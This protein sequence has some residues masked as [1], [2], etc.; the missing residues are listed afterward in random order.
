MIAAAIGLNRYKTPLDAYLDVR[1]EAKEVEENPNTERG[2]FLEPAIRNWS[3]A[4]LGVQQWE[5]PSL[6]LVHPDNP[7]FTYSPDGLTSSQLLEVKSPGP[8]TAGDW[9]EQGT[10]DVPQEYLLQGVFGLA[11]T[12]RSECVFAALIGGELRI[13]KHVRDMELER[14]VLDKAT[15]FIENHVIPGVP[16]PAQY[17]DDLRVIYP[18][19]GAGPRLKFSELNEAWKQTVADFC[20][21]YIAVADAT[22][23]LESRKVLVQDIIKDAPGIEGI[24]DELG[25]SRIDWKTAAPAMNAGTWKAAALEAGGKLYQTPEALKQWLNNFTPTEGVRRFNP[26]KTKRTT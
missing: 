15:A 24:P 25:I 26:I 19:E 7:W 17:G 5:V 12:G 22:R 21:V 20:R 2:R 16:P 6:P 4:R 3:A 11:V 18:K 1:K 14:K 8:F 23:E 13:F 9:G 10:D